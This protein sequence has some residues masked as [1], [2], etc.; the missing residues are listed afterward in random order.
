MT[1]CRFSLT[2]TLSRPSLYMLTHLHRTG[3]CSSNSVGLCVG[4]LCFEC[5][6]G[7]RL[8]LLKFFFCSLR[9]SVKANY[10]MQP[11]LSHE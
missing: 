1:F 4:D 5:G 8:A 3:W 2:F 6:A 10:G 11:R 9:Q 7:H